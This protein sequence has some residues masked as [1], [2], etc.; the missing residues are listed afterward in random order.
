[1]VNINED[2]VRE[3]AAV[4]GGGAPVVTCYLDVDGRRYPRRQDYETQL[5]HLVR[6]A[7]ARANGTPPAGADLAQ[8]ESYVQGGFDR[9]ETRGLALFSCESRSFWKAIALAV[10]VRNQLV[11]NQSPAVGQLELLLHT[12]ERIAVL[13]VDRQ[14][15]RLF[16]FELGI[17]VDR[18]ELLDELPRDYDHRGER[19]RGDTHHHVDDLVDQHLRRATAAAFAAFRAEEYAHLLVGAPGELASAVESYLHPY[20]AERLRGRLSVPVGA[21][22]AVV[23]EAVLEAEDRLVRERETAV[24]E[25]LRDAVGAGRRAVAGLEDVLKALVERRVDLLVISEGYTEGG[26]RCSA[27]S[28]L[29]AVGRKCPLCASDMVEVPD[30]VED[31]LEEALLQSC[32][33]EI[34]VGNADLDVLGRVG[35]FLRY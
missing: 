13:L 35:A 32:R 4:S 2:M 12:Y 7:K 18:S 30:V 16:V 20:L 31:A 5:E 19:E 1:M 15:A 21:S 6:R 22:D 33:I 23:R 8:I 24:V 11:V 29:A 9:A 27:C 26:W 34:C 17:L 28:Y 3:L 25:R 14:Q 10:P